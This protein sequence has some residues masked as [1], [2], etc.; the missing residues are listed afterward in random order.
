MS[1]R[2]TATDEALRPMGRS[3]S[4]VIGMNFRDEDE[5][6]SASVLP[7]PALPAPAGAQ[8]Q[9]LCRQKSAALSAVP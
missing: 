2:F 4:G 9:R 5:L 6:L 8:Y 7:A 1:I 3:T